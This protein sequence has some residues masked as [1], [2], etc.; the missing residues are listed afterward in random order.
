MADRASSRKER[1][2]ALFAEDPDPWDFETSSYEREKRAHTIAAL[3]GRFRKCL[4]IGCATAVLTQDLANICDQVVG[5]DVSERALSIARN[6][7][8]GRANIDLR[9]GEIPRDWPA[10]TFDLIVLSEVLYF[11]DEKEV[12]VS[13]AHA[14]QSLAP[15]GVVL[16]V[17]WIGA[18]DLPLDGHEVVRIFDEAAEWQSDSLMR[19]PNFRIDKLRK[20]HTL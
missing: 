15:D 13:S 3:D 1:F 4:E 12:R 10:G 6:R 14:Y 7:L 17:N 5:I 11:L 18:T 2:E 9:Q 20:K 19:T 8:Y 16:A